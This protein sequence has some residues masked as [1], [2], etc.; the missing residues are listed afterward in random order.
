MHSGFKGTRL[1]VS[2]LV[3]RGQHIIYEIQFIDT[4]GVVHGTMR[5]SHPYD[6][7]SE[8]SRKVDDLITTLLNTA[9]TMHFA[10]PSGGQPTPMTGG[11][12]GG[13]AEALG[14]TPTAPD[15]PDGAPG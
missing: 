1:G 8:I 13:I 6:G 10:S 9:A 3:V 15:E 7:E 11:T 4:D 14:A 2:E 12:S 5:H